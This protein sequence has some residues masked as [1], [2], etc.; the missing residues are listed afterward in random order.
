M[1]AGLYDQEGEAA[2]ELLSRLNTGLGKMKRPVVKYQKRG[3]IPDGGWETTYKTGAHD[4]E[5]R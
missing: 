5:G 2:S 1:Q 4:L 3:Q